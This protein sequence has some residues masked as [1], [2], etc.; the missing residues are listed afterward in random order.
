M[1][2]K[3]IFSIFLLLVAFN[4]QNCASSKKIKNPG[5]VEDAEVQLAKKAKADA[6]AGKKAQKASQKIYWSKQSKKANKSVKKNLKRQ[7]K[8]AKK[9]NKN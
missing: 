3:T 2:F 7:K 6:K 9:R 8:L 1:K 5:N 4:F